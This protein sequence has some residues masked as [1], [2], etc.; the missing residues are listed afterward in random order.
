MKWVAGNITAVAYSSATSNTPLATTSRV[1][2]GAP[3]SIRLSIRDNVGT[4]L[5]AGCAGSDVA[6]VMAE[7]VDSNGNVVPTAVDTI[8]YALAAGSPADAA[9]IG[10][11]NG[12][13]ASH[14]PAKSLVRPV[15][16]GLG[17]TV[18][19]AGDATGSITVTATADG[20]TG[21][22]VTIPVVAQPADG[23][24]DAVAWCRNEPRL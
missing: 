23:S 15:W 19:Q 1:T 20:L 18:V 12:D 2:T 10:T 5:Y 14:V 21:G 9:I 16:H 11:G 7:V 6:L 22:Q 24:F 13:P 4:Q 8:T 3:A 17:L